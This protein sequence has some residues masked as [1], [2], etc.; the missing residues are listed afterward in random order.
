MI[1]ERGAQCGTE[2]EKS[3][4]GSGGAKGKIRMGGED[5][6]PPD[7]VKAGGSKVRFGDSR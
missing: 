7:Q 5:R 4:G 2:R 6:S 1:G 3:E